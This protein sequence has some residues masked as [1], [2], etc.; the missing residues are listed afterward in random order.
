MI[1]QGKVTHAITYRKMAM[2]NCPAARKFLKSQ[3][4]NHGG[5]HVQL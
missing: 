4:F 3:G 5:V 1:F 2:G